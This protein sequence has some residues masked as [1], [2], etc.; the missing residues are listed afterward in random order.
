MDAWMLLTVGVLVAV[1]VMGG[2]LVA[3]RPPVPSLPLPGPRPWW[4]RLARW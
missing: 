3:T 2:A 1:V 4:R